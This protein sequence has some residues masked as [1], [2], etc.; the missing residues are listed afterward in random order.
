MHII[1]TIPSCTSDEDENNGTIHIQSRSTLNKNKGVMRLSTND[2]FIKLAV[3]YSGYP[4]FGG[5]NHNWKGT[6]EKVFYLSEDEEYPKRTKGIFY[7]TH[8]LQRI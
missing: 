3:L 2:L 7:L 8:G 1:V 5:R 6:K 4:T